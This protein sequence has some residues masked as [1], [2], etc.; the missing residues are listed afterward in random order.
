MISTAQ[1]N[2]A[3]LR[4]TTCLCV[5]LILTKTLR[6]VRT[7]PNFQMKKQLQKGRLTCPRALTS[8]VKG[9]NLSLS[10]SN[11]KSILML[12]TPMV[13]KQ[14]FIYEFSYSIY[15]EYD[16]VRAQLSLGIKRVFFFR[17]KMSIKYTALY[18][19]C[20]GI[21]KSCSVERSLKK[22]VSALG[23]QTQRSMEGSC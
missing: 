10:S 3:R 23:C 16:Y 21:C 22:R 7:T 13:W 12:R 19:L 11:A 17:L 8:Q 14:T 5:Y 1:I 2:Q 20:L 9:Q 18:N 4:D 6:I 15:L